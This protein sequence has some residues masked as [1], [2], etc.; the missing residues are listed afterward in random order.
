MLLL[1]D[2]DG[3]KSVGGQGTLR[4]DVFLTEG[5]YHVDKFVKALKVD[6]RCV[7]NG[8]AVYFRISVV[9]IKRN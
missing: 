8:S 2:L 7:C 1:S 5:I 6:F 3:Y 9:R 4:S